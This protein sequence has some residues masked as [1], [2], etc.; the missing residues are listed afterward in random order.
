MNLLVGTI[1][2]ENIITI[3]FNFMPEDVVSDTIVGFKTEKEGS[4]YRLYTVHMM[5]LKPTLD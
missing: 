2:S 1:L 4:N 3:T 5:A